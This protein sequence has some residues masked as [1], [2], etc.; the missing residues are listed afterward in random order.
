MGRRLTLAPG[1]ELHVASGVRLPP[2]AK[3]QELAGWWDQTG[4]D[5]DE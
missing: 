5:H 2:P 3:M 1:V 4:K